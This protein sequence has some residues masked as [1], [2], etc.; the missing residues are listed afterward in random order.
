M[1]GK[2]V[3]ENQRDWDNHVAYVL[4]AYNATEH[5]TTGYSPNMLVYGRGIRFPNELMY[6]DVDEG[7]TTAVSW[8]DFVA[9]KQELFKKFFAIARYFWGIPRSVAR[10]ATTCE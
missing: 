6:T 3:S 5:S 2:V 9:E 8:I 4:A 10:N 7:E 1:L